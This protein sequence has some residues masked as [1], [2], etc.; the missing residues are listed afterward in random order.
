MVENIV[1]TLRNVSYKIDNEI[2]RDQHADAI[3]IEDKVDA[4]PSSG[5]GS[6]TGSSPTS[7][8]ARRPPDAVGTGCLFMKKKPHQLSRKFRKK[9]KEEVDAS[10]PVEVSRYVLPQRDN[11][12]LGVELIWDPETVDLY[13][14]ILKRCNN[15]VTLEAAAGAIHNLI[16]CQWNVCINT[17]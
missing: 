4:P 17:E 5:S 7:G 3:K 15:P 1:C 6:G 13:I 9:A 10:P 8:S 2:D 11:R 14:E 12:P 16:A